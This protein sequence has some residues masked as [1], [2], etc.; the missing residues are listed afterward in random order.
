MNEYQDTLELIAGSHI[1]RAEF[2]EPRDSRYPNLKVPI[3][4]TPSVSPVYNN[5]PTFTHVV[6]NEEYENGNRFELVEF[7][8]F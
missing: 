6:L 8:S 2:R 4:V 3:I 1:H 7:N 5:N